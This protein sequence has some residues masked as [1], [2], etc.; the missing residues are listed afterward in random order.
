MPG[1]LAYA[2]AGAAS[3]LGAGIVER[4]RQVREEAML[5]LKRQRD[6]EDAQQQHDWR[7]EEIGLRDSLKG[8]GGGGRRRS[9]GGGSGGSDEEGLPAGESIYRGSGGGLMPSSGGAP[10][11]RD[12]MALEEPGTTNPDEYST[13]GYDEPA[14]AE[15]GDVSN[16]GEPSERV[17]D[18][19]KTP[20]K[21]TGEKEIEGYLY[22][23]A[24]N[25]WYPYVGPDGGPVKVDSSVTKD[26]ASKESPPYLPKQ[27][28]ETPALAG[29]PEVDRY[30]P[31]RERMKPDTEKPRSGLMPGMSK[32]GEDS[33]SV[34]KDAPSSRLPK[35]KPKELPPSAR[36]SLEISLR[37][38]RGG[39]LDP[40]VFNGIVM[41]IESLMGEGK[42]QA[43]ATAD[44]MSRLER[45]PKVTDKAGN[46]IT[47]MLPTFLGGTP[48]DAPPD[49][50]EP[51]PDGKIKG[52][53]PREDRP[54]ASTT[55]RPGDLLVGTLPDGRTAY[56]SAEDSFPEGSKNIRRA[57]A[58]SG[59]SSG[60]LKAPPADVIEAARAAIQRGAPRDAVAARLKEN[61][62]SAEGI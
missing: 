39:N 29:P 11:K 44:V 54:D 12:P 18:V 38:A 58:A 25:R 53:K 2:A 43:Q 4:A 9:G 55:R 3:G 22:G 8:G 20:S 48:S 1:L 17:P 56:G 23:R 15:G 16:E 26:G 62:Y 50:T 36:K 47:R 7:M 37:D 6:Q 13:Y 51:D 33:P 28:Q 42:T 27:D 34:P 57:D 46:A 45:E 10:A 31:E 30:A 49:A 24:G 59:G 32:P 35:G 14:A 21:L 41:E 40:G 19:S 60:N 52:V 61:G 5:N